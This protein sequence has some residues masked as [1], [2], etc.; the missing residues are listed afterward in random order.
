MG[1]IDSP[2]AWANAATTAG[3]DVLERAVRK[4]HV[5]VVIP[6]FNEAQNVATTIAAL[7]HFL[8]SRAASTEILVVDDGSTDATALAVL[9]L[10]IHWPVALIQLSRN[11]GKEAAITAGFE[12]A[13]GDIVIC[14]DADG[15]HP[16]TAID[17]MLRLWEQGHDMVYAVRRDRRAETRFKRWG[18]RWFYRALGI[19]GQVKIPPN[20]GDF[21]LMDRR[22]VDAIRSM[23]ERNRFMKGL[24][25]WVGFNSV[26]VPYDPTPRSNGASHYSKMKLLALAWSGLTGFSALPLRAATAVGLVLAFLAFGYGVWVI[27]ETL[28]LGGSVPGWPTIVAS[29]MFFSGVQL[30]FIGVLGEYQARI[31]DEVKGRPNYIVARVLRRVRP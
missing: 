3:I 18:V 22:V 30:L 14:I 13:D 5:S 4:A 24:Y 31:F 28:L 21:R 29:I 17:E 9:A 2:I 1:H 16:L 20:A 7:V 8:D 19:A 12:H 26:G 27:F 23:P 10:P 15:Q 25:A 11:F 6:A